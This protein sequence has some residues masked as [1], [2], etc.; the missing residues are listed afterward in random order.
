MAKKAKHLLSKRSIPLLCVLP[1]AAFGLLFLLKTAYM[2]L[3]AP[4]LPPCVIRTLTGYR[5][6]SCGMTHSVNALFRGDLL[7]ALRENALIPA[8]VLLLI[9]R[10]AEL[11]TEAL[12]RPRHLFPR[13]T[14]FWLCVLPAARLYTVLRN[15][16]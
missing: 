5:C 15:I 3:I 12:G 11:W 2:R 6:P 13:G 8:A 4:Y 10:Y 7:T 9:L 14:R 16:L 1:F